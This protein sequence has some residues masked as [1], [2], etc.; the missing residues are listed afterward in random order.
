MWRLDKRNNML[1][2]IFGKKIGMT[3]IFD[4][5]KKALGVSVVRIGRLIV[6]Q[7]KTTEKD[8]YTALQVGSVRASFSDS[9]FADEW[10][11]NKKKYFE[12][13]L[14][15]CASDDVD[16]YE[17]GQELT[18]EDFS[19]SENERLVVQGRSK[20]KGF[21]GVIKRHGF[22][23]GPTTHGSSFHRRPGSS[24]GMASQGNVI[25][26]K[27]MPGHDGNRV[28]STKGL[29]LIRID[30]EHKCLFI[31]GAIPGSKDSLIYVRKQ[32]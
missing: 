31:K 2:S 19:A 6:C 7:V 5:Q 18:L 24:G 9:P 14:E 29:K 12:K 32:V 23:R 21:Q 28:I 25:K 11:K 26:G 30:K 27:K 1:S 15:I 8:G 22:R 16:C 4:D 17:I 3:Q 13:I 20:G 10:L